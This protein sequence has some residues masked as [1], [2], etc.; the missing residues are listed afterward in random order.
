MKKQILTL[1]I[2]MLIGS[3]ITTGVFLILKS[4]QRPNMS[5]FDM[6]NFDKSNFPSRNRSNDVEVDSEEV[7]ENEWKKY[8]R[9]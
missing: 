7:G 4:N 9:K 8:I 1:I 2:G 3:I 5:N 6:S